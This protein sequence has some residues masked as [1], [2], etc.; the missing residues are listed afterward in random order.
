MCK[1]LN[2][3]I[4]S[5]EFNRISI[6]THSKI[7]RLL[8][9]FSCIYRA[10]IT[11]EDNGLFYFARMRHVIY[12]QPFLSFMDLGL[13]CTCRVTLMSQFVIC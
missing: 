4:C 7:V 10:T 12:S 3:K 9:V 5:N 2:P 13:G 6:D 11:L 1:F 8:N